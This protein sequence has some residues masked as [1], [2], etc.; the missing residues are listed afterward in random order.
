MR[1]LPLFILAVLLVGCGSSTPPAADP[2]K[3]ITWDEYRKMDEMEKADHYVLDNLN[4]DAKQ[5][6]A[7]SQKQKKKR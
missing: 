3:K 2:A 5:K 4:D 6:L 7:E 1:R